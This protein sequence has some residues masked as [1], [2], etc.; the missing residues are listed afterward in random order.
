M[1]TFVHNEAIEKAENIKKLN[2]NWK[3]LK[4]K[5]KDAVTANKI[6]FN[7]GLGKLLDNRVGLWKSVQDAKAK[8]DKTDKIQLALFR[9]KLNAL[10]SNAKSGH[11]VVA[12][13]WTSVR[14]LNV[15]ATKA[16][17]TDLDRALA[18]LDKAFRYDEG[19]ADSM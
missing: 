9:V 6:A 7:K 11:T 8:L 19:Y 12:A 17:F 10:K 4:E 13:Y 5:H 3:E 18:G 2:T 1:P 15:A 14:K 16:A